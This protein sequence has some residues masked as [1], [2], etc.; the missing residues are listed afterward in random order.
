MSNIVGQDT[1][2]EHNCLT[3]NI[4]KQKNLSQRIYR[5]PNNCTTR[6][7]INFW[8]LDNIVAGPEVCLGMSTSGSLI[9]TA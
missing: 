3:A 5:L 9:P 2:S 8:E 4:N 6:Y 1:G 7:G